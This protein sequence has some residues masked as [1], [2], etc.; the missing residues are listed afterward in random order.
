MRVQLFCNLVKVSKGKEFVRRN[1][2]KDNNYT[3]IFECDGYVR[4]F[5]T[6]KEVY[7]D[8]ENLKGITECVLEAEYNPQ[9]KFNQFVVTG[10]S[11]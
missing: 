2:E 5:P 10:L 9:F 11:H 3:C 6:T 4:S 8:A 1:G 7:L